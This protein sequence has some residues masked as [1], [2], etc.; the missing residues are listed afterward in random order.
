[1]A[2]QE[3]RT[4]KLAL[5]DSAAEIRASPATSLIISITTD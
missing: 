1:M 3:L 4:T 2:I 5:E